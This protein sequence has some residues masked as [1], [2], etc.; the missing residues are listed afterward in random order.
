[1]GHRAVGKEGSVNSVHSVEGPWRGRVVHLASRLDDRTLALLTPATRALARSGQAQSLVVIGDTLSRARFERLDDAVHVVHVP[2]LLGPL[3][4]WRAL[5]AA[6]AAQF[7]GTPPAA[8]HMHGA[9]AG[10]LG[11]RVLHDLD[12]NVP[13]FHSSGNGSVI[14]ALRPLALVARVLGHPPRGPAGSGS[15]E[16]GA[17]DAASRDVASSHAPTVLE[18]PVRAA[19]FGAP[20]PAV[21]QPLIVSASR[22]RDA[23]AAAGFDQLAVLLGG[24]GL[25]LAFHWI[26][27]LDEVSAA[28][29]QAANVGMLD[30]RDEP[31]R[32]TRL[33]DAWVYVALSEVNA[34]PICL[35]EAMAAGLPCVAMDTPAHRS[36]VRQ[37]ETGYLCRNQGEVIDRIAQLADSPE[38]RSRMGR[39]GR[40]LAQE[41]FGEAHFENTLMAAYA[42][43]PAPGHDAGP[44]PAR[45]PARAEP[46]AA[47]RR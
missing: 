37:G 6:F 33:A 23:P 18:G 20:P 30:P 31:E 4:Q 11:E 27:P 38:L 10:R 5:G 21:R 39:C 14:D 35:A 36:L 40:A 2:S 3:A 44:A 46:A 41:R 26:G 24:E 12:S 15:I 42:L 9:V 28:R 34:F 1:M 13:R 17:P 29:L 25:G 8:V 16:S 19:Y 22:W 43:R 45:L 32:A 7:D 47:E